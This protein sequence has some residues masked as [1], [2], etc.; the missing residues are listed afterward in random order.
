MF[1]KLPTPNLNALR[2]QLSTSGQGY[3]LAELLAVT[4]I[5]VIVSGLIVGVLY[6]TLR[7]GNKTRVTNEVS[8]SANYAL[9]VISNTAINA[10]SVTEVGGASVSDCTADPVGD[11]IEFELR[12]G[13]RVKFECDASSESIASISASTTTYLLDNNS[14]KITPSTCSFSCSQPNANP[15]SQPII[16]VSFSVSQRGT[17]AT[18]ENVASSSTSA[19]IT[20]RNYNP[21]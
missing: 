14:V 10:E 4:S 13:Q 18:F 8:Q 6:S 16:T 17:N 2:E 12:D 7:G 1:K 21:R 11:S 20:M 19:S 3:T 5:I 15:Y 9:S